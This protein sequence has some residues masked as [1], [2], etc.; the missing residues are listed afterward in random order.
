MFWGPITIRRRL[1]LCFLA[2]TLL[3]GMNLIVYFW[4][5]QKRLDTVTDLRA[6]ILR[7]TLLS[8]VTQR[9]GDM[10]KQVAL[11]A[12]AS[13][14]GAGLTKLE[15]QQ[16]ISRLDLVARELQE[17]EED[18]DPAESVQ[19]REAEMILLKLSK[20]W[21]F[22]FD[23]FGTNY[24]KAITELSVR[25]DPLSQQMVQEIL[26]RLK[27][28][29]RR[30]VD[31]AVNTFD[32][33][34]ELT[35]RFTIGIFLLS[36]VVSVSVTFL[37]SRY[38]TDRLDTLKLGAL[39]IGS[40][41]LEYRIDVKTHDELGA[42]AETYNE[43]A[44][45][46]H[47]ARKEITYANLELEQRNTEVEKQQDV[48]QRLLESV[49][50]IEIAEELQ[51]KG[52]VRPKYYE[53]VTIIFTDFVG[54]TVGSEKLA[55]EELVQMLH[56]RFTAFDE[57]MRRYGLEKLKTIGDSYMCAGGLPT[58]TRTHPVD[59]VMAAFEMLHAVQ[60]RNVPG[61]IQ[62]AL[63][64]GI[65]T[66]PVIAG[67]VGIQKFAFDIWGD[68]V[69]YASRMESNGSPNRINVSS[70]TYYRVKDFFECER[71]GKVMTK[72]KQEVEMFY[73]NGIRT[74]LMDDPTI[75][76]PPAFQHRYQI[77]FDKDPPWFPVH[78]LEEAPKIDTPV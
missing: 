11:L 25:G 54:F 17:I 57:I 48:Y 78:L 35:D 19:V 29:E 63:R 68:T 74:S 52:A 38:L 61:A 1:T 6:A 51:A 7:Q 36:V 12:P 73:V 44:D 75:V 16:L 26:P 22:V 60:K 41:S 37:L 23:N 55:A 65:H 18:A 3:F 4:G 66:G 8:S 27:E 9:M 34:A 49:L 32:R 42:L 72:D 46:L 58:R 13:E 64:V 28:T 77:Y 20:S 39:M 71:R 24:S 50:P 15:K 62:W 14:G 56:T 67:V 53:D 30:R 40:G 45:N 59:A 21:R 31:Q 69:N 43:M 47:S 5:N 33:V 10:Q 2:I 76:P 70:R